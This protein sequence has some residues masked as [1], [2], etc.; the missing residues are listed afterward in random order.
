MKNIKLL[1]GAILLVSFVLSLSVL[2]AFGQGGAS[3][4]LYGSVTDSTQAA[5]AGTKVT[6]TN[7]GTNVSWTAVSDAS[8]NYIIPDLPIGQYKVV[9]ERTGFAAFEVTGVSVVVA[10]NTRV[11]VAMQLGTAMQ[12]ITVTAGAPLVDTESAAA[13]G[14]VERQ[15]IDQLPLIN[16]DVTV[17]EVLQAGTSNGGAFGLLSVNGSSRRT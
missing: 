1:Q 14:T 5:I 13:K 8:G 9:A 4:S 16:R 17:L 10:Q 11:N 7:L 2:P 3:A 6:V 12:T 15:F